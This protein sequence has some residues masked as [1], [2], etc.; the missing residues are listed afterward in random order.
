MRKLLFTVPGNYHDKPLLCFLKEAIG[1]S[2]HT[3]KSLRNTEGAVI[4]NGEP[5]RMV[6]KVF[7]GDSVEIIIFE[8]TTPPSLWDYPINIIYE[9]EDI[10][11]VNKPSGISAHPSHNH[12]HHTLS[13]AVAFYLSKNDNLNAAARSIGRLD[14]VTSGVMIFAK[15]S[16]VA[17]RLNGNM[18]KK[19]NALVWGTPEESGTINV[20]IYRPDPDKTERAVGKGDEAVTHWKILKSLEDASL[21]EITTETGRTHQIRVHCAH[22]GHPLIGDV[23]Y[24][25]KE[26]D[27][28]KRAALHCST[29]T[30]KHPIKN[31]LITFTAAL[32]EDMENEIKK[33]ENLVDKP[34]DIC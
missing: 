13:N 26:T 18:V 5:K 30:I 1:L 24:G 11:V 8:K 29:I 10:L 12:P 15:N 3:I 2:T 23:M 19:Y 28:L 34:N 21:L 17:S 20:P 16:Y 6:D 25:G 4:V 22:I 7:S 33:R 31:E 14:K 32:P 9:D 27:S